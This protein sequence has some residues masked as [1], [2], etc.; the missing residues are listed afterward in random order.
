MLLVER[1][2]FWIGIGLERVEHRDA[3]TG[4]SPHIRDVEILDTISVV[5]EPTHTHPC[6]NVFYPLLR[7]DISEGS[8]AVV[9]VEIFASE[10]VDH[11]EVGPAVVV[12]VAPSA[13]ET[14]TRVVFVEARRGGHIAEGSVAIVAHHEI[15]RAVLG[16]VIGRR[17][18][19]LAGALIVRV[20][21]EIDIQPSIAVIVSNGCSSKRSLRR[22]SELKSVWLLLEFAVTQIQKK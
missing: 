6:S 3:N 1:T 7:S 10:V 2:N 12:E 20:E 4:G 15:G 16:I 9:A 19:V 8:I 5:V 17:I 18:F 21:R 14:V 22:S 11:V 13:A